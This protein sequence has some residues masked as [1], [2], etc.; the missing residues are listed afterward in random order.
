MSITV[1][2]FP[3]QNKP[4]SFNEAL[5]IFKQFNVSLVSSPHVFVGDKLNLKIAVTG[6][7]PM[8]NVPLPALCCQPGFSGIFS[9]SDLPPAEEI[10]DHTKI[11]MTDLRPLSAQIKAIPPVEFSFFDPSIQTYASLTSQ[12]I[13]ITVTLPPQEKR[14]EISPSLSKQGAEGLIEPIPQNLNLKPIEISGGDLLT[15]SD[16]FNRPL[17]TLKVL[18]I[19]PL[20]V[21]AILIQ[22]NLKK[23]MRQYKM[24]LK[25]K[26][27]AQ[28]FQEAM[29]TEKGH[30]SFYA[31]LNQAFLQRLVERGEIKSADISLDKLPRTGA[32]AMVREFLLGVDERRFSGQPLIFDEAFVEAAHALFNH[33]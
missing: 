23:I 3:E 32:S 8:E 31:L 14:Q 33:V 19:L 22:L 6:T 11:F 25:S 17:G 16:L 30:P 18:W 24:V 7:G 5:G 26:D 29:Q 4:A 2:A 12:P 10:K 21:L 1:Q 15:P 20:G 27:S 9:P 13:P 28:L